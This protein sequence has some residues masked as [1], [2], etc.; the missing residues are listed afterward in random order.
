MTEEIQQIFNS[1]QDYL[2]TEQDLREVIFMFYRLDFSILR[3]WQRRFF[4]KRLTFY[5][6]YNKNNSGFTQK[7]VSQNWGTLFPIEDNLFGILKALLSS[8]IN[9]Q[10]VR[11]IFHFL[12][13][14]VLLFDRN[15]RSRSEL[16][17]DR[18]KR[19][20]FAFY[21]P[22]NLPELRINLKVMCCV[23]RCFFVYVTSQ[24]NFAND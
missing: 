9:F 14:F 3:L 23:H 2:N 20:Q 11:K 21:V 16:T 8:S 24:I 1:F 5:S 22:K 18:R 7:W 6:F 13:K 4:L 17:I 12:W 10:D 15:V 19:G